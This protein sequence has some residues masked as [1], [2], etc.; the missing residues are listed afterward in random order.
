MFDYLLLMVLS[1]FFTILIFIIIPQIL[2]VQFMYFHM[3][4]SAPFLYLLLISCC[5]PIPIYSFMAQYPNCLPGSRPCNFSDRD[6]APIYHARIE[7]AGPFSVQP[8]LLTIRNIKF[9]V[10]KNFFKR[11]LRF[12][13]RFTAPFPPFRVY[14]PTYWVHFPP[15]S[16]RWVCT[17]NFSFILLL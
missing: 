7:L 8:A 14:P 9:S 15:N 10:T 11:I 2:Y 3:M 17:K 5:T 1:K 6:P 12:L 4:F 13:I 16:N